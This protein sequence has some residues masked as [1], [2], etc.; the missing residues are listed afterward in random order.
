MKITTIKTQNNKFCAIL[1]YH[2]KYN[3]Y[4]YYEMCDFGHTRS[5]AIKNVKQS[6]FNNYGEKI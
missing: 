1:K 4:I 2:N 5:E 6:Y 3:D